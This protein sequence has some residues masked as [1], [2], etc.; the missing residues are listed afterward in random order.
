[1]KPEPNALRP[2]R[3]ILI[4]VRVAAGA[5][6]AFLLFIAWAADTGRMPPVLRR[7]YDY[8]NG[9]RLGHVRVYGVLAFLL[10][11]VFPATHRRFGRPVLV[12][13]AMLLVFG[14]LEE[15]SQFMFAT[16]TP[17]PVDLTCTV[18]GIGLGHRLARRRGPVGSRDRVPSAGT[19]GPESAHRPSAAAA[20][21]VPTSNVA[22]TARW[23]EG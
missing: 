14:V 3:A 20:E 16:R 1:M 19:T 4:G 23:S 17:D 10:Q 11:L 5:A 9:D 7:L 6:V 22:T 12:A 21:G 2:T 8:P 15:L 18:V 13:V